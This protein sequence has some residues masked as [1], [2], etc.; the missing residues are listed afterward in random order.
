[1]EGGISGGT[2]IIDGS[3][4]SIV[5]ATLSCC[6][7]YAYSVSAFTVSYGPSTLSIAFQTYPDLSGENSVTL[8]Y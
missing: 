5:L 6:T 1:M 2:Y 8:C 3:T 4:S 7:S